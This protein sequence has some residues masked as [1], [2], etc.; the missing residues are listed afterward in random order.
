M[1][2][3]QL[4]RHELKYA[5]HPDLVEAVRAYIC[6]YCKIDEHGSPEKDYFYTIDSLYFDTDE[7]DAYWDVEDMAPIRAKLRVRC[8]PDTADA[9]VKLEVK[10]RQDGLIIKS[11]ASLP[12]AGWTDWLR[13]PG[14]AA[15]LP[16]QCREALRAFVII[17]QSHNLRPKMLVRYER[18][19]YQSTVDHEV[20]VTFDRNM[21]HQIMT[22][23][24][25]NGSPSRWMS[26]DDEQSMGVRGHILLEL[27]FKDRAPVWMSDLTRRFKLKRQGYSKY[28]SAVRRSVLEETPY[29]DL[30]PA[31]GRMEYSRR[32]W[33][34]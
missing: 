12:R 1:N 15:L 29:W 16:T 25:L 24:E 23:F 22:R 28:C 17:M 3:E 32:E 11:A 21:V 18:Q 19:A 5:V 2:L 7:Y 13:C 9:T 6:R 14:K 4:S 26:M 33:T 8:Y 27:K 31:H 20:R 30:V 34:S 10:R